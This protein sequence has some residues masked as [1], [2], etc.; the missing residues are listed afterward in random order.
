MHT[1]MKK[2]AINALSSLPDTATYEDAMY[3]IYVLEKIAKGK[4]AI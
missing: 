1:N 3:R 4:E 2:T